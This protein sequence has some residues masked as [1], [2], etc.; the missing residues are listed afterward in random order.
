M[1]ILLLSIITWWAIDQIKRL[2]PVLHIPSAAQK[3]VTV[4]LAIGAGAGFA[5]GY[6]LDLLVVLQM[7]DA[8]SV[9]GQILA[10]VAI[11]SGSS[12]IF[13]LTKRLKTAKEDIKVGGSL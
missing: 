9:G 6:R 5:F 3:I 7:Q 2:Y 8:V 4:V 13:E 11:A 10:M 12:A 1:M